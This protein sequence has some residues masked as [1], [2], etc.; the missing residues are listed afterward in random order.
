VPSRAVRLPALFTR[1]SHQR[2][3]SSS[4]LTQRSGEP[5]F[6]SQP[7]ARPPGRQQF[8]HLR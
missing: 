7:G 2:C 4:K 3:E 1:S 8:L 5:I 6:A